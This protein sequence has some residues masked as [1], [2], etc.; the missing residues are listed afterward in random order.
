[1]KSFLKKLR[2]DIGGFFIGIA[3]FII[4]KIPLK[5]TNTIMYMIYCPLYPVVYL[6][7]DIRKIV[8]PNIDIVFGSDLTRRER[9]KFIKSVF[10]NLSKTFP[11]LIYYLNPRN[12]QKIIEN[13]P[14]SGIEH[15]ESALK[16]G[17]GAILLSAHLSNFVLMIVR[18]TMTGIPF[19]VVLKDPSNETLK[20][21]YKRYQEICGIERI[22]A[23]KGFSATKDILR[24]LKNNEIVIIVAD[25]RKKRDGIIVPFFG[26][27]ALTAPGPAILVLRSGAP[28]VPAFIHVVEDSKFDI[29][30]FPP[31][32]PELTGD[33]EKDI[34]NISLIMN[35]V[36][37]KQIRRYPD[38]WAWTNPRW[39]GAG[40]HGTRHERTK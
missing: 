15:L 28:I 30:I 21:V 38:Q 7:P 16:K 23:D 17:K 39:K 1:M 25:E 4:P 8:I 36:I 22:D 24:A 14:I 3:E 2:Y 20:G 29:E 10:W 5:I 32:E 11:D 26:R 12:H 13:C 6:I 18:L 19:N 27:D 9:R 31:I 34:Y 37:E 35:E 33:K 40:R